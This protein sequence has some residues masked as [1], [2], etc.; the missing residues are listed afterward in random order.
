[1][2]RHA[3]MLVLVLGLGACRTPSVSQAPGTVTVTP[4]FGPVIG[5]EVIAGRADE[6]EQVLLLAGSADLIRVDLAAAR[7]SRVRLRVGAAEQC[8]SLARLAHGSLWTLKGRRTL[9]RV[10]RDGRVLEE[11]ALADAHF[12]LFAAG[13]R[14]VYQRADFA[15][16]APA[17][18]VGSP[19]G[20]RRMPWSTIA[21]RTFP[22]LARASVAALN[23]LSCGESASEERPCWFPDE[24]AVWMVTGSGA[25]RRVPLVGL[26][27]VAPETLLTSDH[28]RR[29]V[30][31]AYVDAGG[32]IWILSSGTP[33]V[34]LDMPGGWVLA[35]YAPTGAP[36]GAARLSEAARILLRADRRRILVLTSHGMVGRVDAW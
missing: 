2:T 29:P 30:R 18:Q 7:S 27:V 33:P 19:D 24:A 12:G 23:M 4:I 5:P 1:M 17:L 32:D 15:P 35:R 31:D 22:S 14:L 25:T 11:T 6:G 10:E 26:D 16:P 3:G 28:P 8:W 9:A 21:T 36:K 34:D 20:E 13:D